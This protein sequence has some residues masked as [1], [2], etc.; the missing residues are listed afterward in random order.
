MRTV[1]FQK[2]IFLSKNISENKRKLI[3]QF[4]DYPRIVT[5]IEYAKIV[6]FSDKDN[7]SF[8]SLRDKQIYI[9][10]SET[11]TIQQVHFKTYNIPSKFI[12]RV[13]ISVD[14]YLIQTKNKTRFRDKAIRDF[15]PVS[16]IICHSIENAKEM[17]RILFDH[18][19]MVKRN[20][21]IVETNLTKSEIE[22]I[23]DRGMYK[24]IVQEA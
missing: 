8:S 22:K 21:I 1:N 6:V 24:F 3:H 23:V 9:F 13:K 7:I 17:R 11:N 5:K 18:T 4:F 16:K 19:N 20:G 2:N 10:F 15:I 14:R 12:P